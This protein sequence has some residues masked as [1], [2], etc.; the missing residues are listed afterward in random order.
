MRSRSGRVVTDSELPVAVCQDITIQLDATGNASITAGQIDNGSTDNCGIQS[1]S[2]SPS[3]FDCSN[4]GA[5]TVTL[6]VLDVNGNVGTCDATVTV[7]DNVAPTAICQDITVQLDANGEVVI[8]AADIDNG[9]NDNCGAVTL[10]ID[11]GAN[12][13]T[14]DCT[15]VGTQTVTLT[16]TD[17]NGNVSTC[18]AQVTIE[19]NVAP[20]AICQDITVQLDAN[21]EVVITAADI[22]NGSNDNCG[23]VT[24]TIDGGAN[25]QT[26]DCTSVGTQTVTLTVTDARTATYPPVTHR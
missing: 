7:E 16:V 23:A 9:S 19:D 17:Q 5:N 10:T 24:L 25:D 26:F 18:D 3:T 21:G 1:I 2:V 22:D 6:S 11:G 8:T 4:V 15:S 14:F 13:Q 20:T 12:D